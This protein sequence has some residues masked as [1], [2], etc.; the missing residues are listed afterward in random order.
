VSVAHGVEEAV[1]RWN[2]GPVLQ[3][4]ASGDVDTDFEANARGRGIS[5][6][7]RNELIEM[8]IPTDAEVEEVYAGEA[9]GNG[10]P[11]LRRSQGPRHRG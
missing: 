3:C 2:E 4:V 5:N 7:A 10:R 9:G 11:R 8:A 6:R 1:N